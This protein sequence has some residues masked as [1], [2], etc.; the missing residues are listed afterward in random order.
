M[1]PER[2]MPW[3]KFHPR[4]WLLSSEIRPLT[5]VQRG[6]L[7]ELMCHDW[8]NDGVPNSP[9]EVRRL[10]RVEAKADAIAGVLA[11]FTVERPHG[12]RS[13]PWMERQRR[14]ALGRVE[15]ASKGGHAKQLA[16]SRQAPL[17]ACHAPSREKDSEEEKNEEEKSSL[18]RARE[19]DEFFIP[20]TEEAAVRSAK[21][22]DAPSHFVAELFHQMNAVGWVDAANRPV[23]CWKS[24]IR[25]SYLKNLRESA[26]IEAKKTVV[27]Q[28]RQAL[29]K[30]DHAKGFFGDGN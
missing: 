8:V 3:F 27:N 2:S 25:K 17:P 12:R 1:N 15:R 22:T 28:P 4:D 21:G 19:E 13:H 9:K 20:E 26:R 30:E 5:L 16:S 11:L 23:R 6:L 29:T 10:F 7:I 18:H 24:Y 14:E